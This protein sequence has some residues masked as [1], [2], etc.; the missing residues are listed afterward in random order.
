MNNWRL[1][2]F[3]ATVMLAAGVL[4]IFCVFC[5]LYQC[6]LILAAVANRRRLWRSP[7][8]V[9]GVVNTVEPPIEH[10]VP[11]GATPKYL[12]IIPAHNEELLLGSTLDSV[13]HIQYPA[14][15]M[16]TLV[17][18]DNCSDATAQIAAD[19]GAFVGVRVD[20]L[21]AG[22]GY[23]LH[24]VIGALLNNPTANRVR[25]DPRV[26]TFRFDAAVFLDADTVVHSE[27]L[28]AFATQLSEGDEILQ[29]C[30]GVRNADESMRTR[31]MTCALALAHFAKPAGR[32]KLGLSDG[33]KGNGFCVSRAVMEAIPLS[34]DSI[35]EDIEY[36]LRLCEAGYKVTFVPEALVWAQMP[37]GGSAS[38]SQRRRWESGRYHLLRTRVPH[39]LA[40][41][42]RRRD[43]RLLDR[44]IELIIPP[45][46]ELTAIQFVILMA[47]AIVLMR[48]GW[49]PAFFLSM[50]ALGTLALQVICL[51]SAMWLARITVRIAA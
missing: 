47:S 14:E 2:P 10:S 26:T 18:A 6:R 1:H 15:N 25:L 30:Y 4:F 7:R 43:A 12:I 32:Q 20:P 27:I 33:L 16:A 46:A 5:Q 49:G 41:A 28:R 34:G 38:V 31:L 8:F 39:L 37:A 50:L 51:L 3:D 17:I 29:A 24:D 23:V 35:T 44:V 45:F 48:T 21:R 40:Q 42:T 9:P 36:T 22:K 11:A 19:H 13:A